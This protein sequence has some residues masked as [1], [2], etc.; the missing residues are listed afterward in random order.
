MLKTFILAG[1]FLLASTLPN[2]AQQASPGSPGIATGTGGASGSTGSTSG[3][4]PQAAS[5]GSS[6]AGGTAASGGGGAGQGRSAIGA[7]T[8]AEKRAQS[9]SDKAM[10]ICKGC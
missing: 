10:Q 6:S 8:D 5:G 2:F 9:D 4:V 7:P 1:A 3:Q